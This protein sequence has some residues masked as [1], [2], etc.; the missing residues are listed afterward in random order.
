MDCIIFDLTCPHEEMWSGEH[1][2]GELKTIHCIV[3]IYPEEQ[4]IFN[5]VVWQESGVVKCD[6][7]HVQSLLEYHFSAFYPDTPSGKGVA[8]GPS[9]CHSQ[10]YDVCARQVLG[11]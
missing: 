3:C 8:V 10:C 11:L 4:V 7:A 9:P 1:V 5:M 6:P 2:F